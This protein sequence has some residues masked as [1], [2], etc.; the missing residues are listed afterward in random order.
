[1]E[2]AMKKLENNITNKEKQKSALKMLHTKILENKKN[3]NYECVAYFITQDDKYFSENCFLIKSR[4]GA[5]R[6]KKFCSAT[7]EGLAP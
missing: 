5:A 4:A 6:P 1:M 2:K 3:Q 7:R